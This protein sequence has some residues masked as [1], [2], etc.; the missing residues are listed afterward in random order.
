MRAFNESKKAEKTQQQ[1]NV[2]VAPEKPPLSQEEKASAVAVVEESTAEPKVK[3]KAP[4]GPVART[5]AGMRKVA[6]KRATSS[7]A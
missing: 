4:V 6:N 1:P 5:A 7:T 3:P 2:D